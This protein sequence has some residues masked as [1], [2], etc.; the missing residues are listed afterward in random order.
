MGDRVTAISV[1]L[2]L[3]SLFELLD[4]IDETVGYLKR[5]IRR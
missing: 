1:E 4:E 2:V 5:T 3:F